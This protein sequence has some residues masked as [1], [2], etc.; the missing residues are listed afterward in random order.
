LRRVW[1]L[2]KRQYAAQAF[3]GLGA[4]LYGGRWNEEGLAVVY[5]ADS[6]SLAALETFV[7]LDPE[8][9]PADYLAIAADLPGQLRLTRIQVGDLPADWRR[10]PAPDVL[11]RIG[12]DWLRAGKT[13]VLAV[14]SVVVPQEENYLL[15]P[16]HRDFDRIV[17]HVAVPFQFDPRM[18]K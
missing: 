9:L 7:H 8:L 13:A 3:S 2:C 4:K 14:P 6:L 12:S 15:N 10:Y 18:W 1:R 16:E 5:T 17:R 11:R